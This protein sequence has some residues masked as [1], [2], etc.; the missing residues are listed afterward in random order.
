MLLEGELTMIDGF[1]ITGRFDS[2]Q[3]EDIEEYPFADE[4]FDA[5]CKTEQLDPESWSFFRK[6]ERDYW[7]K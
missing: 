1:D 6:Q 7:K 5:M 3:E 4:C 2:A